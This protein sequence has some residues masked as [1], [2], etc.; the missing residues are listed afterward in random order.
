LFPT[1][2]PT[3]AQS[4]FRLFSKTDGQLM[5]EGTPNARLDT[6][7]S[8]S[9]YSALLL[10]SI[11]CVLVLSVTDY[12]HNMG[13]QW[14]PG[15]DF[16]AVC[17]GS[18]TWRRGGNPYNASDRDFN[19]HPFTY[20]PFW[21]PISRSLCKG[22]G[23][24]DIKTTVIYYPAYLALFLGTLMLA[25]IRNGF[26]RFD[27]LL[28]ATIC[29]T[30]LGGFLWVARGGN[31]ALFEAI[32]FL[33]ALSYLVQFGTQPDKF[34]MY[35]FSV[36]FGLF[37]AIK[38]ATIAYIVVLAL[39]PASRRDRLGM[40][41]VAGAVAIAPL[42]ISYAFYPGLI[43]QY[44]LAVTSQIGGNVD[45]NLC[46]PS[47]YCFF[48]DALEQ[49][50]LPLGPGARRFVSLTAA[51]LLV[52]VSAAIALGVT[53]WRGSFSRSANVFGN[54]P[55][56]HFKGT[57]VDAF[58]LAFIFLQLLNPRFKEYTYVLTAIAF[59]YLIVRLPAAEKVKLML[60]LYLAVPV[61]VGHATKRGDGGIANYYVQ[62][63]IAFSAFLIILC[64]YCSASEAAG[65]K[66][67]DHP[68]TL[69]ARASG[70]TRPV[71]PDAGGA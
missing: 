31:F 44:Y 9:H 69:P 30:G 71:R 1:Y 52:I 54:R 5:H 51:V 64:W 42:L 53:S 60:A 11:V 4:V 41:L 55:W 59:A 13:T 16:K 63:F 57:A 65:E 24:S 25:T 32:F 20:L 33:L 56:F 49:S 22:L 29:V 2:P 48:R 14:G 3:D 36:L 58:L 35:M 15:W 61:L 26:S 19:N 38:S 8:P 34:R 17:D 66:D 7:V 68:P 45:P 18:Y 40:A 27:R 62:L 10:L 23:V 6:I 43:T 37:M 39:V 46:N 47:F 67:A 21:L 28:F 70:G 50:R 12:L